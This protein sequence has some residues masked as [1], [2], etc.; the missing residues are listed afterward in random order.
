M[1]YRMTEKEHGMT[2]KTYLHTVL[3]LSGAQITALKKE[4]LGICV[5]LKGGITTDGPKLLVVF[6]TI[7]TARQ[8][9]LT[10]AIPIIVVL[11]I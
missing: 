3:R 9:T 5:K 1:D 11:R 10:F 2:V 6:V 4:P 8:Y 7:R